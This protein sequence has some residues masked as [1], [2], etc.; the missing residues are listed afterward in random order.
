M[1]WISIEIWKNQKIACFF[2]KIRI[3]KD[4]KF[5]K[6]QSHRYERYSH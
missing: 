4:K 1:G 6:F 3:E 5:Q 2:V